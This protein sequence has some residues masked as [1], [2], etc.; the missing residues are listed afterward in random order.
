MT[1]IR[2][3]R[4]KL[5]TA[6]KEMRDRWKCYFEGLSNDSNPVD[7]SHLPTVP[8]HANNEIIPG[9]S[10]EEVKTAVKS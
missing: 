2:D 10:I 9:I 8:Q 4:D 1:A 7:G 5:L 3:E 6:E